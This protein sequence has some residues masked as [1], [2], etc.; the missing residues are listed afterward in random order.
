M[1]RD[2][3]LLQERYGDVRAVLVAERA[4]RPLMDRALPRVGVL[5]VWPEFFS[6][7]L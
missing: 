5:F 2:R 1:L 3:S 6:E 4:C 7:L